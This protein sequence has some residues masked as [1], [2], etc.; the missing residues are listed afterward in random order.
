MFPPGES[1]L[2]VHLG[3]AGPRRRGDALERAAVWQ[4]KGT[5]RISFSKYYESDLVF[6]AGITFVSRLVLFCRRKSEQRAT[7]RA[8]ETAGRRTSLLSVTHL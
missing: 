5:Q 2:G 1:G 6:V 8:A 3:A 7:T 4:K